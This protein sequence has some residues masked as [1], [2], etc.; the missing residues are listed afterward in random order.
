[1]HPLR[2]LCEGVGE[3]STGSERTSKNLHIEKC[4]Q[5]MQV[6]IGGMFAAITATYD[7]PALQVAG[8]IGF[9]SHSCE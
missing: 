8:S 7:L 9:A 6:N 4:C 1:M 2:S 3:T 5:M